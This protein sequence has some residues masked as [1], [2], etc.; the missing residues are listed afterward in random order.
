[1]P[2]SCTDVSQLSVQ[3]ERRLCQPQLKCHVVPYQ[4]SAAAVQKTMQ[5]GLKDTC[6]VLQKVKKVAQS[7]MPPALTGNRRVLCSSGVY[8]VQGCNN[9]DAIIIILQHGL[10]S[11]K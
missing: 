8:S 3:R 5:K 2:T 9:D 11:Q 1:M 10:I 4:R 6:G 7:G